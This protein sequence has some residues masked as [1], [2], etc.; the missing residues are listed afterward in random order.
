[1]TYEVEYN[2]KCEWNITQNMKWKFT[3]LETL[4]L[5]RH[6]NMSPDFFLKISFDYIFLI[7]YL[8]HFIKKIIESTHGNNIPIADLHHGLWWPIQF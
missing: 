7:T 8:L 2:T 3:L 6:E 5:P 4:S 1:M